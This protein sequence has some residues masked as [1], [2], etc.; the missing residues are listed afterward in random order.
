MHWLEIDYHYQHAMPSAP[1]D[2]YAQQLLTRRLGYALWQP[3]PTKLG[4]V[5]I[6]DV[7]FLMDGAFYR[8]FNAINPK[9]K[10]KMPEGFTPLCIPDNT[11]HTKVLAV[12]PGPVHS[13]LDKSSETKLGG[14]M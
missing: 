8:L 1:P 9:P 5:N 6:G 10:D 2:V 12:P 4:E 11:I 14:K 7:G 3:E 13:M